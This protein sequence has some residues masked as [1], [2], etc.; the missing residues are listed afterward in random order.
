MAPALRWARRRLAGPRERRSSAAKP[1][2]FGARI[3]FRIFRLP[4][5]RQWRWVSPVFVTGRRSTRVGT[6]DERPGLV[7]SPRGP[8]PRAQLTTP[9]GEE[10]APMRL[11]LR[12]W[13]AAL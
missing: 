10:E 7:E 4:A 2:S 13:A 11:P 8:A 12:L 5:I 6:P 3:K 1:A 9:S